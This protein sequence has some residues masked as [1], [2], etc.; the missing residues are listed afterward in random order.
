MKLG[1]LCLGA[2]ALV[3]VA[4]QQ[5][6]TTTTRQTPMTERESAVMISAKEQAR[7]TKF[8]DPAYVQ[9]KYPGGDVPMERGVCADVI[10]RA[11]RAANIDLQK[12][13]HEDMAKHFNKYP[14]NWGLRK[15][16]RNI[17]HRRVL[18]LEVWFSRKG[19]SL[20]LSNKPSDF[21]AGDIVTWRLKDGRAH[22]G[23]VTNQFANDGVTPLMVHNIGRG[24]QFEDVLFAWRM[25]GHYRV[26]KA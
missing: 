3:L 25:I 8:Y 7:L 11:L 22:T 26:V 10:V 5:T 13:L 23:M 2:A 12:E 4:C 14:Q 19:Y 16:D 18:N 24:T 17:D 20:P 15:P 9:L 21:R 6:K 1:T